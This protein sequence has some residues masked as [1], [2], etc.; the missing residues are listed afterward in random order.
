M[1]DGSVATNLSSSS[2][3]VALRLLDLNFVED[4]DEK[5]S[6]CDELN[7]SSEVDSA[8]FSSLEMMGDASSRSRSGDKPFSKLN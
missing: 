2:W 8:T 1:C 7:L 6:P 3:L 5:E 4:E